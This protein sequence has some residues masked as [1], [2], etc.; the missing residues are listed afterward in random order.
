MAEHAPPPPPEGII[1]YQWDAGAGGSGQISIALDQDQSG[2]GAPAQKMG[3]SLLDLMQGMVQA[4]NERTQS[5]GA[6]V[7]HVQG[8]AALDGAIESVA[9]T[10]NT[11]NAQGSGIYRNVDGDP[12]LEHTQWVSATDANGN[13]QGLLVLD[14]NG[15]GVVE[16]GDMLGDM[17]WLDANRDGVIDASDPAFAAIK[18]WVD[19]N[20][21]GILQAGEGQSL[22]ALHITGFDLATGK[23]LYDDGSSSTI[24]VAAL[25]AD[26]AGIKQA[27]VQVVGE[28]GKL[29]TVDAGVLIEHEAADGAEVTYDHYAKR[30]GDWEGTAEQD[31]HRHGGGNAEGAPTE[32]VA[33]GAIS[34]GYR[35]FLMRT[36]KDARRRNLQG[37]TLCSRGKTPKRTNAFA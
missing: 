30:T 6:M 37:I 8:N 35:R 12:Y 23:V 32:T 21:D 13:A 5:Y 17:H 16:T 19:I 26:T 29:A 4:I 27:H 33:T 14:L 11:A 25:Q 36:V 20:Q 24:D 10:Q 2:G 9:A 7:V 3:H 22:K 34:I 31:A 18:L 1:H 15:N 28:D